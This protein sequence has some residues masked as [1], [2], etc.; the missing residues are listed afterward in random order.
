MA[1]I[2]VFML[3]SEAIEMLYRFATEHKVKGL[4]IDKGMVKSCESDSEHFRTITQY[5][6]KFFFM[7]SESVV[8]DDHLHALSPRDE[9]WLTVDLGEEVNKEGE[10]SIMTLSDF[11][12]NARGMGLKFKRWFIKYASV[13]KIE[14]GVYGAMPPADGNYYYKDIYDTD[15]ARQLQNRGIVWKQFRDGNIIF[16]PVETTTQQPMSRER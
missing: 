7:V 5:L 10:L 16:Y 9:D 6:G 1:E 8:V 4:R 2:H 14:A 13:N 11:R 12:F 15:M 3:Q